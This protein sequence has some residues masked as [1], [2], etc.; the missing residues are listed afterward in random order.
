[1]G[2]ALCANVIVCTPNTN[3][4]ANK[5]GR[6]LIISFVDFMMGQS[7]VFPPK[8]SFIASLFQ[9]NGPEFRLTLSMTYVI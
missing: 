7:P 9:L 8:P 2:L 5:T 1:M 4:A 3:E 6:V